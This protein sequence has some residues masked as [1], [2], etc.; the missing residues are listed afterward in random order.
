MQSLIL[1]GILLGAREQ[2]SFRELDINTVHTVDVTKLCNFY[3]E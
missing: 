2:D 3:H 1:K